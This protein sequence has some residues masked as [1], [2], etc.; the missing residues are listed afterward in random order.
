MNSSEENP[1]KLFPDPA[2]DDRSSDAHRQLIGLVGLILPLFVWLIAGLRPTNGLP[3]WK[4]LGS[5]SA[6]YYTAAVPAFAGSLVAMGLFLFSYRGYENEYGYRDRAAAIIAGGAALLIALFP[7]QPPEQVPAPAWWTHLIGGI[8]YISAAILFSSFVFFCLF[9]FTKSGPGKATA[10]KRVRNR[11]YIFCGVAIIA[12][13]VWVVVASIQH[14]SI[15]W[16][17]T[18]ALEFFALS[19]LLKG[20]ADM[21]A[22]GVT[23]Q[24]VHYVR[25]PRKLADWVRSFFRKTQQ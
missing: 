17:E 12:C 15:F 24:A 25:H 1:V 4:L 2:E 9:Q 3:T 14:K 19:W 18:L 16:P 6:Y 21:T 11:I 8:H 13:L 20:R 22:V 5:I 7:T 23:Q 10:G